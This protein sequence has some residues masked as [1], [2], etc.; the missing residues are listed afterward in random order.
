MSTK[1]GQPQEFGNEQ[2]NEPPKFQGGL[3]T[4]TSILGI[5]PCLRPHVFNL[6]HFLPP[7]CRT[8]TKN[9]TKRMKIDRIT[10]T[11]FLKSGDCVGFAKTKEAERI[12]DNMINPTRRINVSLILRNKCSEMRC[13]A[14]SPKKNDRAMSRAEHLQRR[15]RAAVANFP[16]SIRPDTVTHGGLVLWRV[17]VILL[18]LY[19]CF[20][21]HTAVAEASPW[22]G[23]ISGVLVVGGFRTI[24]EVNAMSGDEKRNTLITELAG[25]TKDGVKYYQSLN[26]PDLAG[27]GALLVY[28][29]A[30]QSRTDAQLKTMSADDMRNTVI[31]EVGAKTHRGRELQALPNMDLVERVFQKSPKGLALGASKETSKAYPNVVFS[32]D[33]TVAVAPVVYIARRHFDSFNFDPRLIIASKRGPVVKNHRIEIPLPQEGRYYFIVNIG[34]MT[35]WADWVDQTKP[36]RFD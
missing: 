30:N 34:G 16:P 10:T 15:M 25:R 23:G 13:R 12:E 1:T 36:G 31:V 9:K 33:T 28:L 4:H 14:G 21:V 5:S 20:A 22:N 24:K 7:W 32:F 18:S 3:N 27:A 2:Q 8:K 11:V 19:F 17:M 6:Q 29:R 26:D 35:V